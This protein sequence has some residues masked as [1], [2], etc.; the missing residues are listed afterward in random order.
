MLKLNQIIPLVATPLSLA[1]V[2]SVEAATIV[3]TDDND[4]VT[5]ITGLEICVSGQ[6]I[7][8][9]APEDLTENKVSNIYDVSFSFNPFNSLFG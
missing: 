3:I 4:N 2:S 9:E 7:C 5:G 1:M 8:Q 6:E